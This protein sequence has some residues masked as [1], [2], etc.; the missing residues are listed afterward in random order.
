MHDLRHI[1]DTSWPTSN[2]AASTLS[3]K[4]QHRTI[5]LFSKLDGN[6]QKDA[7]KDKIQA[8]W[9]ALEEKY[10]PNSL[11]AGLKVEHLNQLPTTWTIVALCLSEDKDHL[12]ISRFR[13]QSEPALLCIPLQ[14]A[15]RIESQS[16]NGF[17]FDDATKEMQDIVHL[18]SR[19]G[20]RAAE[21]VDQGKEVRS[22]WWSER[23]ALDDR[24]QTLL[25]N[26]EYCWLGAFKVP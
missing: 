22:E 17:T 4:S 21:I 13:P 11:T 26:M 8:Y 3:M 25:E 20:K 6:D 16:T 9:S 7:I 18:S 5:D 15:S 10:H 14:R 24:L 23:R 1:N 2:T 19:N 12:F